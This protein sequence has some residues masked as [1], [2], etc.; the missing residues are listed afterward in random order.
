MDPQQVQQLLINLVVNARDAMPNGGKLTIST[1][2]VE[3]D[4]EFARLHPGLFP[5]WNVCLSVA[6][7]GVGMSEE[8]RTRVFEPFFTTKA[9]GSGTGLGLSTVY[10]IVKASEGHIAV[11]SEPKL[12]TVFKV[13]L[14]ATDQAAVESS[15][16]TASPTAVGRGETILVAEDE[17]KVRELVERILTN[18]GYRVLS[19]PSGSTGLDMSQSYD[20]PIDLLVTDLIMPGL[21]GTQLA[22][23]V[24]ASRPETRTIFMSGYPD[25][26]LD[27]H[28]LGE[29]QRYL[30]KPF[31]AASLLAKVRE[32]LDAPAGAPAEAESR[33]G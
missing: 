20:G 23:A 12:G 9:R 4:E 33:T 17:D 19:A 2:N 32:A 7:T 16:G 29:G 28:G 24:R 25:D 18:N 6:D 1:S 5:G 21:S 27:H 15:P 26:V 22:S 10:G 11:Y 14:P 8:V 31:T 3:V 13:Y 30:S